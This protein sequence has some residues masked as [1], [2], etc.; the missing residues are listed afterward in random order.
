M[1][2]GKK[3][4]IVQKNRDKKGKV[5]FKRMGEAVAM[6]TWDNKNVRFDDYFDESNKGTAFRVTKG[7]IQDLASTAGLQIME[8]K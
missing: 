4:E 8:K 6:N 7:K 2:N 3:Y 1:A 5:S